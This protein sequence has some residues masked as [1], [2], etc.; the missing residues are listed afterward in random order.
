MQRPEVVRLPIVFGEDFFQQVTELGDRLG[1]DLPHLPLLD[2][3]GERIDGHD[4]ALGRFV[5]VAQEIDLG[6]RHLPDQPLVLGLAGEDDALA[7]LELLLH[8][9]LVEPQAAEV[10]GG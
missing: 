8:E 9:R 3:L 5:L 10:A 7:D 1:D 2:A 6:V 4:P